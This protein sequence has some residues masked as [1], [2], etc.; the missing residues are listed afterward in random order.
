M[1]LSTAITCLIIIAARICDMSLDTLRVVAVMSGNRSRS[2]FLGFFEVFIWIIVVS[3]IISEMNTAHGWQYFAYALSYALG[4]ALGNFLGLT[5]EKRLALGSQVVRIFTRMGTEVAGALRINGL[6]VTEVDARGRDGPISL[7]F[8][9]VPRKRAREIAELA[10][11]VDP[12]CYFVIDDVRF[13]STAHS[14]NGDR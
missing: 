8:T 3:R 14:R 13:A 7:L 12:S 2:F 6:V 1:I 4:F 10:T 11:R 5:L 9:Q